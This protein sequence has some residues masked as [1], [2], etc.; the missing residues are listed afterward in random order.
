M[1]SLRTHSSRKIEDKHLR[2]TSSLKENRM[3]GLLTRCTTLLFCVV[4]VTTSVTVAFIPSATTRCVR[5]QDL[6]TTSTSSRLNV[7]GGGNNPKGKKKKN[8]AGP[9]DD[10]ISDKRR[11]QLGIADFEDEYD[12]GV[13]FQANTD[14]TITKII[15]GSLIIVMIGL[16]IAGIVIPATTDYGEGIC[17]PLLTAGRC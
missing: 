2:G 6:E 3:F 16:L 8:D 9:R 10:I 17:N 14:D 5:F 12:L 7:F 11:K 4:Y 15:A 1:S 13:A